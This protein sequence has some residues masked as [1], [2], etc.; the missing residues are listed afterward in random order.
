MFAACTR[1][2]QAVAIGKLGI[3]ALNLSMYHDDLLAQRVREY[4]EAVAEATPVGCFV[5]NH[6][7]CNPATFVLKDDY[8]A[9]KYGLCGAMYFTQAMFHYYGPERP[10]GKLN[11][12][13]DFPPDDHIKG[14]RQQRN[15]PRSQLSC[16]IGD[17]ISARESVQRFVDVGVDELILVMQTGTTPHELTMESIR[18]F[19]E[20]V[21]SHFS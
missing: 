13:T 7:A 16:I 1:P 20:E 3:G 8:R 5:T 10:V 4:R 6:F 15:S 17:P 21:L 12:P 9:C 14:F 18:T 2:E 11:V 19:G